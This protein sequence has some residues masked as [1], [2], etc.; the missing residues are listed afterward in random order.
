ME[1][2]SIRVNVD[3]LSTLAAH[4][5]RRLSPPDDS[6][7]RPYNGEDSDSLGDRW[8]PEDAH[9]RLDYFEARD[10]FELSRG[11]QVLSGR[12]QAYPLAGNR[13]RRTVGTM[14]FLNRSEMPAPSSA[15]MD[16]L[17]GG[18]P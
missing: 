10:L 13:L 3:R 2:A 7:D 18:R 12:G 16:W 14:R 11:R 1:S 5:V 15:A 6:Q 8:G 17:L 9:R 4:M